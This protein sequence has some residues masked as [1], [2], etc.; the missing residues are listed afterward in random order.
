MESLPADSPEAGPR[1]FG[2]EKYRLDRAHELELN[3][4]TGSE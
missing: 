4:F 3:R 1:A 2:L